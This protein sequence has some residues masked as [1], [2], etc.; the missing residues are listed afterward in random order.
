MYR[1][2]EEQEDSEGEEEGRG[3]RKSH[4]DG[5]LLGVVR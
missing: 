4:V 2:G 3:R 5:Q 1:A